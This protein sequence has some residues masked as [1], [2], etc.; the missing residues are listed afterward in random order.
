[1]TRSCSASFR[2]SCHRRCSE[3]RSQ[4]SFSNESRAT[5]AVIKA[6]TSPATL[7]GIVSIDRIA[8]SRS[9]RER[10]SDAPVPSSGTSSKINQIRV[11]I[12]RSAWSLNPES[13]R[14]AA[15][16]EYSAARSSPANVMTASRSRPNTARICLS[17]QGRDN[18]PRKKQRLLGSERPGR[19][20]AKAKSFARKS[21][22]TAS[23]DEE[24]EA[25]YGS[26]PRTSV[27]KTLR[28]N[29]PARC[30]WATKS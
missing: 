14:R 18:M 4:Y 5:G 26:Q 13:F 10:K 11:V 27:T 7:F 25:A 30:N 22:G 8:W 29:T 24:Y 2:S 21:F 3:W 16:G 23:M 19:R 6:V 1:M 20:A 15:T 12:K 9:R 17:S 28:F